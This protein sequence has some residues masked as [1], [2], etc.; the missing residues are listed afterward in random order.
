MKREIQENEHS[1]QIEVG[2]FVIRLE[3]EDPWLD[4]R[5]QKKY[6]EFLSNREP[7]IDLYVRLKSSIKPILGS[8]GL[9]IT[10]ENGLFEITTPDSNMSL[11]LTKDQGNLATTKQNA[12]VAVELN[13]RILFAFLATRA[14]GFLL[15]SA[16]IEHQ[17][18][19]YLFFGPSGSGKTT[20]ARLS[21][22]D[23]VLN[24]DLVLLRPEASGW[25]MHSTP[26][27]NP[28]QVRPIAMSSNVTALFR[29]VQDKQVFLEAI[30]HAEALAE[31]IAAIPVLPTEPE[32]AA[33]LLHFAADLIQA[34][35]VYRL[36]F[37]P[38]KKF[39]NLID[40]EIIVKSE[41]E[42]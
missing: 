8:K 31:V 11:D 24:D 25:S 10:T 34:V 13:L 36:H 33:Q 5:I 35:P 26:F 15:H 9:H 7:D 17:G 14:G 37:L 28:D 39:W 6:L 29:L 16:G 19:G 32:F 2:Y 42:K 1:I 41:D 22:E 27:T 30:S 23:R 21:A 38:D 20:V 3:V 18:S 12:E 4:G 40:N